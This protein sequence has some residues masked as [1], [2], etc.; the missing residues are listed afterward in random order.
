MKSLSIIILFFFTIFNLQ[1]QADAIE[2][3][4]SKYKDDERFTM[5]YVSPKMFQMFTKVAGGTELDSEIQDIISEL[6]GLRILTTEENS[7]Q[8]YN[9][10]TAMINTKEYEELITVRD[11]KENIKF[12][13]KDDSNGDIV[14]ELLLL[15][16]GDED[17]VLMSFVGNID[18]EKIGKLANL[19]EIDGL[20]HLDK[21]KKEN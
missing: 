17:F 15:V 13:V 4:F 16:G 1:G 19:I 9:E 8:L 11:K 18:L 3:Y 20:E 6:K 5:V 10:A 14:H 7:L 2:K 12:M 21:I